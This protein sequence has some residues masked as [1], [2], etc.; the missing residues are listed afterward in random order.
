MVSTAH[1]LPYNDEDVVSSPKVPESKK[2]K[3]RGSTTLPDVIK[4]KSSGVRKVLHYNSKGQPIGTVTAKYNSYLGVLAR[5]AISI[6]YKTWD[7]VEP[8]KK[9]KVWRCVQVCIT[10]ICKV[11]FQL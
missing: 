11:K 3:T 2:R 9:E 1:D 6:R 8:W 5:T 10:Y 7:D 4:D